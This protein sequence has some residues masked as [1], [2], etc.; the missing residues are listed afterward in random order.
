VGVVGVIAG[1]AGQPHDGI[2]MDADE[3]PGLPD[4]VALGEVMEDGTGLLVGHPAVEERG[5]LPLGEAGLAGLAI[6]QADVVVLAVAVAD[7]EVAGVAPPVQRTF[8]V[9]AAEEGEVVH[10]DAAS[11]H[12]GWVE[13]QGSIKRCWT[14]YDASSPF[15]Q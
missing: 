3:T 11:R 10:G 5:A 7:R 6:Q 1:D 8:G 4:A 13:V 12:A 2:A 14:S 15:V 9:L